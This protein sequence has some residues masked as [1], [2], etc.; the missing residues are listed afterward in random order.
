MILKAVGND[1]YLQSTGQ[2]FKRKELCWH[3]DLGFQPLELWGNKSPL[4]KLTLPTHGTLS[5]SLSRLTHGVDTG[6]FLSFSSSSPED[7]SLG[8]VLEAALP[9]WFTKWRQETQRKAK[10][11]RN[12]QDEVKQKAR[13]GKHWAL[14]Q[15]DRLE[16]GTL[17]NEGSILVFLGVFEPHSL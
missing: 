13:S 4:T 6:F 7:D 14:N 11:G 17:N 2:E 16:M 12:T 9:A 1:G 8:L 10:H 5:W 3:L 15:S